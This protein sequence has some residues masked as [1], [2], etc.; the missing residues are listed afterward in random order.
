[1]AVVTVGRCRG[2]RCAR[3]RRG[4][5]H[6]RAT[7]SVNGNATGKNLRNG[8]TRAARV[9]RGRAVRHELAGLRVHGPLAG[10]SGPAQGS[11]GTR[12]RQPAPTG[13]SRS[14]DPPPGRV[15]ARVGA[16]AGPAAERGAGRHDRGGR[17]SQPSDRGPSRPGPSRAVAGRRRRG[18]KIWLSDRGRAGSRGR[19]R[20]HGHGLTAGVLHDRR[21]ARARVGGVPPRS[22]TRSR[23]TAG[24]GAWRWSVRPPDP[25]SRC[26]PFLGDLTAEAVTVCGGCLGAR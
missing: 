16:V 20:P 12:F 10:P 17:G 11:R 24:S 25:R 21:V 18:C 1:M 3:R 14:V 9:D 15:A 23:L 6:P 8:L 7:I 19:A 4:L 22:P 2:R 5:S 26:A 13:R